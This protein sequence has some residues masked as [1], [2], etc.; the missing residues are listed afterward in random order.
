GG[1]CDEQGAASLAVGV[2]WFGCMPEG[3]DAS[4]RVRSHRAAA[5]QAV[6]VSDKIAF[7]L[8]AG[9]GVVHAGIKERGDLLG[10][11][12][13]LGGAFA[14][15]IPR[16]M[17]AT[18]LPDRQMRATDAAGRDGALRLAVDLDAGCK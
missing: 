3:V 8:K 1:A 10:A 12:G 4:L 14:H 5:I 6:R 18:L 17:H 2:A 9:A 16:H 13:C 11:T 15:A 7:G